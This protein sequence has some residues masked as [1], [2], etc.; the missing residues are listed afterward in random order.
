MKYS[1]IVNECEY[2]ICRIANL[3]RRHR[4]RKELTKRLI[5]LRAQQLKREARKDR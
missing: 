2:L 1:R 3:A 4:K 5:A